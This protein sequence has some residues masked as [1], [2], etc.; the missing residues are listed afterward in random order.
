MRRSALKGLIISLNRLRLVPP[1]C[2]ELDECDDGFF[3]IA[4]GLEFIVEVIDYW[5]KNNLCNS[6]L[7]FVS[8]LRF[9]PRNVIRCQHWNTRRCQPRNAPAMILSYWCHQEIHTHE[10]NGGGGIL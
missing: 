5:A 9:A 2:R 1:I 10:G 6:N 3:V 4:K 7:E 8:I